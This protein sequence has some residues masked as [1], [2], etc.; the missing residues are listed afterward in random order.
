MADSDDLLRRLIES[1]SAEGC[2]TADFE[3]VLIGMIGKLRKARNQAIRDKQAA[4]LLPKGWRVVVELQGGCKATAYNRAERG[5]TQSKEV[6]A[7]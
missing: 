3:A 6:A 5:R 2:Q 7:G 4:E 1:L